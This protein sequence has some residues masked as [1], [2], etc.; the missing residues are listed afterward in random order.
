[1]VKKNNKVVSIPEKRGD[2]LPL[3]VPSKDCQWLDYLGEESFR[4]YPGKE[5]W[6]K[7]LAVTMFMWAE[8]EDSFE[9]NQFCIKYGIPYD[10]LTEYVAKYPDFK[11]CYINVK[12]RLA[13][14]RR[15]GA[16]TRVL[17]REVVFRDIHVY[18]PSWKSEVDDYHDQRKIDPSTTSQHTTVI[19]ER[20]EDGGLK[21]ISRHGDTQ[22]KKLPS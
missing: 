2:P 9:I 3:S 14:R 12:R 6:R 15:I 8:L 11:Q 17:D 5:E 20:L 13:T 21:E 22:Q 7:R 19:L 4:L 1:M 10:T 18:D 16:I